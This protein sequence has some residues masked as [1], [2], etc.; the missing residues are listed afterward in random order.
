MYLGA[1]VAR[2][3]ARIFPLGRHVALA[4][5]RSLASV[6]EPLAK[7][8]PLTSILIANRGEIALSVGTNAALGAG[9][10]TE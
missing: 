5:Q 2:P 7:A 1:T 8:R 3:R 4:R 10:D 6:V 9:S